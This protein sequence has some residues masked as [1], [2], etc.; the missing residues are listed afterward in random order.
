[1]F[2]SMRKEL[3]ANIFWG[4]GEFLQIFL[5][6]CIKEK[7]DLATEGG[8]VNCFKSLPVVNEPPKL[9]DFQTLGVL[10]FLMFLHSVGTGR[11][12]LRSRQGA[13][14]RLVSHPDLL[15]R[16]KTECFDTVEWIQL[17]A[18]SK[19]TLPPVDNKNRR[20]RQT[21]PNSGSGRCPSSSNIN[22]TFCPLTTSG[23]HV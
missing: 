5:H 7:P 22:M 11:P 14:S 18:E 16:D 10:R 23:S 19:L 2:T 8:Q 6:G 12:F 13:M 17:A 20:W 15:V 4:R 3:D 21:S 9:S 1:M